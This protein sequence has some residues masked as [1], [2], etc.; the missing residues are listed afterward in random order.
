MV[1]TRQGTNTSGKDNKNVKKFPS[2][3]TIPKNPINDPSVD[4]NRSSICK[5]VFC[6]VKNIMIEIVIK[7]EES[8]EEE[9]GATQ[10]DGNNVSKEVSDNA[11][12][13]SQTEENVSKDNVDEYDENYS[14]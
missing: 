8:S 11:D 5:D 10:D 9:I 1:G 12:D 7:K 14:Q 4:V 2:E 3:G 13:L 6:D